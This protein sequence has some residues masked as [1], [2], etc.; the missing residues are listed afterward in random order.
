[1][2]QH[3]SAFLGPLFH[4]CSPCHRSKGEKRRS[5][6]EG[7]ASCWGT[8][9]AWRSSR[10]RETRSRT[11]WPSSWASF[12]QYFHSPTNQGT[13]LPGSVGTA[14][15]KIYENR[16]NVRCKI[17]QYFQL[18]F[19]PF[20]W[21]G[22]SHVL[23][24]LDPHYLPLHDSHCDCGGVQSQTLRCLVPLASLLQSRGM[25][26]VD[27][28]PSAHSCNG[29]WTFFEAKAHW[30]KGRKCVLFIS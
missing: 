4:G 8:G 16:Q 2:R 22:P 28:L 13:G 17:I 25:S 12:D 26:H 30:G 11:R 23:S 10:H 14:A 19:L 5:W 20:L 15:M 7:L 27:P 24:Y 18:L 21:T 9:S 3:S 6:A 1:M 29:R